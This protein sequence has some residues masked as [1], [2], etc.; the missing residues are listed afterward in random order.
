MKHNRIILT[1]ISLSLL[2]A[3]AYTARFIQDTD[4]WKHVV[5][6]DRLAWQERDG[7]KKVNDQVDDENFVRRIYL[8]ITGKIPTYQQMLAFRKSKDIAKRQK[9]I[10][11]LLD[12]PGYVSNFVNFWND[13]LRNPHRDP[14]EHN[15]RE[16]TR[17]IE[18]FLYENRPYN[19][20]V[21]DM[22]M[23]QGMVQENQ[24]IGFYMRD[25]GTN[26]MDT[27]NASVRAFLGTRIGC[28]Q[29]HNHRFDKW[30]QKEFYE[31]AA[32]LWG[33]RC[34]STLGN[35]EEEVHGTHYKALQKDSRFNFKL[36]YGN[37]LF[38]PSVARVS[39]NNK[40]TLK[41]PD[42]Y[43]YDNAKPNEAVKE[44]IVFGYGD[45]KVEGANKREIFANWMTSKNNPMFARIMANRLW[46]RITGMALLE[47][48]DDWKDNI[49]V[50]NP[51][52]FEAL[53]DIFTSVDYDFKA[54][55]SILFNSEAY[56]YSVDLRNEFKQ[57]EYKVQG[58]T[59]KRMSAAQISD[60]LLTLRHGDLDRF[61]KLSDDYFAFED[62]LN[63]I[64]AEYVKK[65]A[66]LLRAHSKKHGRDTEEVD[67]AI[68]DI[69][70]TYAEKVKEAEE[71]YNIAPN[72]YMNTNGKPA[73]AMAKS[74]STMKDKNMMTMG[75]ND[76]GSNMQD[77]KGRMVQRANYTPSDFQNVFGMLDRSS[78][79]TNV[80]TGAT[81]KQIL[82][83]M[84]SPECHKVTDKNSYL[85]K[86]M[87]KLKKLDDRVT[88]L[89]Y[90]IFGRAPKKKEVMIAEKFFSKSDK[91]DRWSKYTL[92]L[93]N[94][95]EFYF[96]K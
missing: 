74:P 44:R 48:I 37:R 58:A 64:V 36:A 10:D 81:M 95:P 12:S 6:V 11:Q 21:Y 94:S 7:I 43:V 15:H 75:S 92:A 34:G 35:G 30:T 42:N 82:K 27:L 68:L 78:P 51:K 16:F 76:A 17:Y 50:K 23:A 2:I 80:D 53:G 14:E 61:S 9:L 55:L 39:I 85:M 89:Y 66:P 25:E 77:F 31:S 22:I 90:S 20:I 5:T 4:L 83:M 13:L 72:G 19:K 69:M 1:L 54:F 73:M 91:P 86:E 71:Y 65:M 18:R 87:W 67:P 32:F 26:E 96:I 63:E 45:E 41:Y 3:P 60:S 84:N 29:C 70:V 88:F 93:L 8:D 33:V 62:K 24:A 38:R 52:L 59:L 28:A 49:E 46:K 79:E 47:P 57:D 56:Q 40:E